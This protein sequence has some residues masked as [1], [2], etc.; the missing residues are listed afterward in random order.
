MAPPQ[1]IIQCVYYRLLAI[2]LMCLQQ[3]DKYSA[4]MHFAAQSSTNTSIPILVAEVNYAP[5]GWR[6]TMRESVEPY[7]TATIQQ[8]GLAVE[9][10][11]KR[12]SVTMAFAMI[13]V[14]M[15]FVL[16]RSPMSEECLMRSLRYC[17]TLLVARETILYVKCCNYTNH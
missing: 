6:S 11:M 16:S 17:I 10:I 3:F 4:I 2:Q 8:E 14:I 12:S 1:S 5:Q 15:M 13:V 9:I 7:V